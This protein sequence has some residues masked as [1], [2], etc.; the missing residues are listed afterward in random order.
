MLS[1]FHFQRRTDHFCIIER[2]NKEIK[3]S[4]IF[5]RKNSTFLQLFANLIL[6]KIALFRYSL[7]YFADQILMKRLLKGVKLCKLVFYEIALFA[8]NRMLK[9][10]WL[11][12]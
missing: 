2:V 12:A 6:R 7:F 5:A 9:R 3:K 4:L 10:N 11:L 8:Y 1:Q